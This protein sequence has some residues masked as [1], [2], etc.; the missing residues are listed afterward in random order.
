MEMESPVTNASPHFREKHDFIID[1]VIRKASL[2]NELIDCSP[3]F[4]NFIADDY[5]NCRKLNL[6][7]ELRYAVSLVKGRIG[8]VKLNLFINRSPASLDSYAIPPNDGARVVLSD[9]SFQI[10]PEVRT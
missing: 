3:Y 9:T 10:T 7:P 6:P 2:R 1:C 4:E 8:G 5:S